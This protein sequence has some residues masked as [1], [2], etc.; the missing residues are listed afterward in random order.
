MIWKKCTFCDTKVKISH[1][2]SPIILFEK[3]ASKS[4]MWSWANF[5]WI[6]VSEKVKILNVNAHPSS[7]MIWNML[8]VKF[9]EHVQ[10]LDYLYHT[11]YHA[12]IYIL[13][14]WPP[15]TFCWYK[16]CSVLLRVTLVM[17][18][19]RTNTLGSF[20]KWSHLLSK[21]E[22]SKNQLT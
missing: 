1:V 16:G 5:Q 15:K 4:E 22:M 18:T 17:F 2:F 11:K 8:I 12:M 14:F 10:L 20:D 9:G 13:H 3:W 6:L 21:L 19:I 7:Q